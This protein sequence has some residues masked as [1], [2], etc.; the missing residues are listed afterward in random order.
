VV[1]VEGLAGRLR[2]TALRTIGKPELVTHALMV[3][4]VE[5]LDA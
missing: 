5:A 4:P 1:D 3:I 2:R